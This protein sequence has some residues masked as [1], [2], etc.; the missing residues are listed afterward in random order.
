MVRCHLAR[1]NQELAKVKMLME[2]VR[3][4]RLFEVADWV[5]AGKPLRSESSRHWAHRA[6]LCATKDGSHSMVQVLLW[7]KGWGQEELDRCLWEA[8]EI[9]RSD[10]IEL[11]L[12]AGADPQSIDFPS[13]ARTSDLPLMKRFIA[14]GVDPLKNYGFARALDATRAKPM[15]RLFKEL[16]GRFPGLDAELNLALLL[17]VSDSSARWVA[18][19]VWA[20]AD[21]LAR[22]PR[23]P[24]IEDVDP[25]M[26]LTPGRGGLLAG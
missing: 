19:L 1:M 21:P 2:L 10:L 18:L 20:G 26:D 22:V 4:G 14:M 3:A 9:R 11:L 23:S 13:L 24:D 17:A 25:E 8:V 6:L 16:R 7:D 15:L 12:D 5:R